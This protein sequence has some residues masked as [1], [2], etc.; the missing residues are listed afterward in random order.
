MDRLAAAGKD[1]LLRA[2][3]VPPQEA[4]TDAD[5]ITWLAMRPAILAKYTSAVDPVGL[6]G[7]PTSRPV[8]MGDHYAMRFQRTVLQE[9]KVATPWAEAGQVTVALAGELAREAGLFTDPHMWEPEEAP[10]PGLPVVAAPGERWIDVDLTRQ[11]VTAYIGNQPVYRAPATTGK[12]GWE[13]PT[14]EF[15]IYLR[16]Y[17]ETMDSLSIGV[18]HNSP[19]GYYLTDVMYTQYFAPGG[20]AIHGNYW[21]PL[22]VVGREPTSHGCVGLLNEDARYFWDFATIGTRVVVHY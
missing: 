15:R 16:V 5:R 21:R 1:P 10:P 3:S 17:N 9:W 14:G 19:E 11:T 18:P 6:Y 4:A 20:V 12:P 22:E 7:L 2:R 8:D 13:T